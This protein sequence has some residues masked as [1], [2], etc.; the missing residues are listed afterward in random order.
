ML[1]DSRVFTH[2]VGIRR[3]GVGATDGEWVRGELARHASLVV[4]P[5]FFDED[6][7]S[8]CF[9]VAV[10]TLG[11]DTVLKN[12]AGHKKKRKT[13]FSGFLTRTEYLSHA[14]SL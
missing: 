11:L 8:R 6:R 4:R 10:N 7:L 2:S 13:R 3:R 5:N 14:R 9:G 1:A 12:S